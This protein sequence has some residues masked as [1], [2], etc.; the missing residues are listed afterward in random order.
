[1]LI[2][3][4]FVG[5]WNFLTWLAI[6]VG[7]DMVFITLGPQQNGRHYADD[8]F[9][10]IFLYEKCYILIR[11][12]LKIVPKGPIDNNSTLVQIMAEPMMA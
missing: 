10:L 8:I 6:S 2:G 12:S 9:K 11:I 7:S 3:I 1:M 4:F 5:A